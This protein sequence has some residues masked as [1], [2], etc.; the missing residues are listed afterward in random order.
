M[1]L[2]KLLVALTL[3]AIAACTATTP[4]PSPPAGDIAPDTSIR[5]HTEQN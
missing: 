5:D 2:P 4:P 1:K 3:L